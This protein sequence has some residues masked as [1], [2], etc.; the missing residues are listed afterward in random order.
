M[1]AHSLV[2]VEPPH[3]R[4]TWH[5]A[6]STIGPA[7]PEEI[8]NEVV[9]CE[10]RNGCSLPSNGDILQ[11]RVG[12]ARRG[13]C[14]FAQKIRRMQA[15]GAIAVVIVN[16][17]GSD[18]ADNDEE[19]VTMTAMDE[20]KDIN[21]PS[22][23]VTKYL[24]D[25]ISATIDSG[26]GV[27]VRIDR[28][29][30][31]VNDDD[32]RAALLQT[33]PG[34]RE[35]VSPFRRMSPTYD[36]T[37]HDIGPHF[38]GAGGKGAAP[39]P[40]PPRK[41]VLSVVLARKVYEGL[42]GEGAGVISDSHSGLYEP[43]ARC[44]SLHGPRCR[45]VRAMFGSAPGYQIFAPPDTKLD[46]HP[47]IIRVAEEHMRALLGDQLFRSV[48]SN[49]MVTEDRVRVTVPEA[50]K[51]RYIVSGIAPRLQGDGAYVATQMDGYVGPTVFYRGA[52]GGV[53]EEGQPIVSTLV[54]ICSYT[55]RDQPGSG[56]PSGPWVLVNIGPNLDQWDAPPLYRCAACASR[57][58]ACL[59]ACSSLDY[60][61]HA[62]G[63]ATRATGAADRQTV[64]S[65]YLWIPRCWTFVWAAWNGK[66]LCRHR[67]MCD[68]LVVVAVPIP[69]ICIASFLPCRRER[70]LFE[71]SHR[72][73]AELDEFGDES[74]EEEDDDHNHH[75]DDESD[76][77]DEEEQARIKQR[78]AVLA[79]RAKSQQGKTGRCVQL[80]RLSS[81]HS[82]RGARALTWMCC[83][84]PCRFVRVR[85]KI[86][87]LII[88]RTD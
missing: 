42:A 80:R 38:F 21:I 67:K 60:L 77:D 35:L 66:T 65:Y 55:P 5:H 64:P 2:I 3:M 83:A 69:S 31:M 28:E 68:P 81:I 27:F 1:G 11:G 52:V 37:Q 50:V 88:T 10:P 47:V 85:V 73:E 13:G 36:R 33:L 71:T 12:M 57:L 23:F 14:D 59:P 24:G 41:E 46:N 4:G 40:P 74:I 72:Q 51:P 70:C 49:G 6:A 84:V 54:I 48:K 8:H 79:A 44:T 22:L 75:Y 58:P 39:P 32:E 9:W 76:D 7:L 45:E 25:Q 20:A 19:L 86:M 18:E 82:R 29:G 78:A 62:T 17:E 30:E 34:M 63:S 87:G 16:S 43:G 15:H 26:A 61:T 56:S 53:G